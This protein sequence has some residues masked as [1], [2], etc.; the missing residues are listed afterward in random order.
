MSSYFFTERKRDQQAHSHEIVWHAGGEIEA[1][2]SEI[3][4]LAN[5]HNLS[6]AGIERAHF[7]WQRK[8]QSLAPASI[9][10]GLRLCRRIGRDVRGTDCGRHARPPDG[11]CGSLR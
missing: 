11:E 3:H 6:E 5:I 7:E 4:H 1:I 10:R 9:F 2:A 8:L